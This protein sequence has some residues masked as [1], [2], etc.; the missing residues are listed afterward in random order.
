M[1]SGKFLQHI[2]NPHKEK[3]TDTQQAASP[4]EVA[5]IDIGTTAIRMVI[6]QPLESGEFQILESLHQDVQL[7][8]DTFST[9][10]ID[11]RTI[12]DCVRTLKSFRS[13]MEQYQITDPNRIRSVATSAV[14]EASN[15][16]AFLDRIY[17][18][19]GL[20]VS[21]ADE[22]DVSRLLYHSVSSELHRYKKLTQGDT[23]IIE[24]AGG[25]TE[26]LF[27]SRGRV[28]F[29]HTYRIG[30]FRMRY[31][32]ESSEA[33]VSSQKA[34][35]VNHIQR[36]LEQIEYDFN[37]EK[38]PAL[39]LLGGE[40]RF[41]SQL[42]GK[43]APKKGLFQVSAKRLNDISNEILSRSTDEVVELYNRSFPD[44][45]T[46][47][48]A[49]LSYV[50]MAKYFKAREIYISQ[51]TMRDG[52]LAEMKSG[53]SISPEIQ[54]H[55]VQAA[56]DIGRKYHFHKGHAT[57]VAKLAT[58]LFD[59]LQN[60]HRLDD[61]SR[62]LLHIAALLHEIGYFISSQSHHRHSKYLIENSEIFGLGS[63]DLAIV[64]MIAR[65][66]RRASPRASHEG[67]SR[68]DRADRTI[69][70]KLSAILRVADAL[71][72]SH[73]QRIKHIECKIE[74]DLFVIQIPKV[75]DLTLERIA[76]SEKGSLFEEVYGLKPFLRSKRN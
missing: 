29:S 48:P 10:K 12:E 58:A 28:Q 27:L 69:V 43:D 64:A 66:H 20:T 26:L 39:L 67:Y 76:L 35:M 21:I 60:E 5:V 68:L 72:R 40:A 18:A 30:S 9:Q 19:T 11:R 52:L 65:Y 56:L 55:V 33:P 31:L 37:F 32:L 41:V 15:R 59:D 62:F 46:L 54:E 34:I 14:R 17:M 3:V 13:L 47:G 4:K 63:R 38:P 53:S 75:P 74:K 6:A 45:D 24:M 44:A 42:L 7:G 16:V 23:V 73:S 25:S 2:M 71:D 22:A 57:C 70:T 8:R 49:L 1:G 51:R 61:R 36:F 50:M